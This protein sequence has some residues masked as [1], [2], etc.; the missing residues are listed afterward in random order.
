MFMF[1]A[2]IVVGSC[3][4]TFGRPCP[5]WLRPGIL[6]MWVGLSFAG[7]LCCA[8]TPVVH[9]CCT[10]TLE[11]EQQLAEQRRTAEALAELKGPTEQHADELEQEAATRRRKPASAAER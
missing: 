2:A 10:N 6:A 5:V 4:P 3:G 11:R 1:V 8:I 7:I 9:W